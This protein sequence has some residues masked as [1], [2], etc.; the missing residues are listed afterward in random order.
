MLYAR[1]RGLSCA[2]NGWSPLWSMSQP[3]LYQVEHRWHRA[4]FHEQLDVRGVPLSLQ[5]LAVRVVQVSEKTRL[6]RAGIQT[7][8]QLAPTQPVRAAR[9]LLGGVAAAD[10]RVASRRERVVLCG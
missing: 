8:W 6:H 3:A 5:W 1:L 9:T 2:C 10:V 4:L 7:D